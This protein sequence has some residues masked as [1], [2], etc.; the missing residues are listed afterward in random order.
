MIY[1]LYLLVFLC[2]FSIKKESSGRFSF[3]AEIATT[4]T[5]GKPIIPFR[6][7]HSAYNPAIMIYLAAVHYIL[8]PGNPNA[9][10][11]VVE[12]VKRIL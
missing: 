3:P 6:I 1:R 10:R 12:A 4:N 5:Y 11:Q 7:D 2:S 9:L 8:Y